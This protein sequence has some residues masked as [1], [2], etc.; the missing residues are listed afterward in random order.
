[1]I[2]Q[3][4]SDHN[5]V[6]MFVVLLLLGATFERGRAVRDDLRLCR[7]RR[8]TGIV[9]RTPSSSVRGAR[10]VMRHG[11]VSEEENRHA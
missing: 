7:F 1:M 6:T 8:R 10:T 5:A 2:K 9:E 4:M 3:L 11:P